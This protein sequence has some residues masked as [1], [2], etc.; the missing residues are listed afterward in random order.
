MG[1]E[2]FHHDSPVYLSFYKNYLLVS[3]EREALVQYLKENGQYKIKTAFDP[4]NISSQTISLFFSKNIQ[5]FYPEYLTNY[6]LIRK[7]AKGQTYIK[8]YTED[9]EK[10]I[11]ILLNN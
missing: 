5:E 3:A 8:T 9:G 7:M 11:E 10:K 2:D 6:F 4:I 1:R